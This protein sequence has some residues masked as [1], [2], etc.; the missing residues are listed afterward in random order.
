MILCLVIL[1]RRNVIESLDRLQN[2]VDTLMANLGIPHPNPPQPPEEEKPQAEIPPIPDF[3]SP[4]KSSG[5][6]AIPIAVKSASPMK[7]PQQSPSHETRT[8]LASAGA[9][10]QRMTQA[11]GGE[12]E[13]GEEGEE[14]QGGEGVDEMDEFDIDLNV[15]D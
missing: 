9:F 12:G 10:Q 3:P 1:F 13:E 2:V 15:T 4:L 14:G 6:T 7:I 5:K 8:F 11:V